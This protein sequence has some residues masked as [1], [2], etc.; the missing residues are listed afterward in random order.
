MHL[1][2]EGVQVS[3]LPKRQ[4][5]GSSAAIRTQ[6]YFDL[7]MP[8]RSEAIFGQH[9]H[10]FFQLNSSLDTTTIKVINNNYWVYFTPPCLNKYNL[11]TST[12]ESVPS[13][14]P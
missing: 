9:T 6:N 14:P 5:T 4:A 12:E 10:N 13:P 3:A 1:G 2:Q 7:N 8:S 11:K